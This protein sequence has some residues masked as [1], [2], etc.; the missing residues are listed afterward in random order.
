MVIRTH[1]YA[2]LEELRKWFQ[3]N[4]PD[5]K[6]RAERRNRMTVIQNA[7]DQLTPADY[8]DYVE[9]WRKDD[10]S[11]AIGTEDK[12][13]ALYYLQMATRHAVPDIRETKVKQGLAVW[14]IY[15][16]GYIFKT[17][18][19]CFGIDLL[20]RDSEKLADILDFLLITHEH[21]D[22]WSAPLIEAMVAAGKPVITRW[23]PGT[24]IVDKSCEFQFG[25]C[26]VKV[27]I[28]DHH[29]ELGKLDDML[30]F[31]VDCGESAKQFTIYHSG[32]NSNVHKMQPDRTVDVFILHV[33]V[34]MS[35]EAAI[36]HIKPRQ[37]LVSHVLELEHRRMPPNAWRWSFDDAFE[38]IRNIPAGEA[39]VLTWG[40]RWLLPQTLL[41]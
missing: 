37:T 5:G 4:P 2:E 12:H 15:N 39:T 23:Y 8:L 31:Q 25:S 13:P 10:S 18:N 35:V 19:A 36:G 26:R 1:K 29:Y 27:D 20:M 11:A 30:M 3:K 38:K 17:A 6:N 40:E 16:M 21:R 28:G 7:C 14:H 34:G 32:D 24:T 33:S 9:S 41:E 22:H